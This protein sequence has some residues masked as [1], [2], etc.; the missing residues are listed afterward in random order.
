[1]GKVC[2]V[3]RDDR[4]E[5]ETYLCRS[6]KRPNPKKKNNKDEDKKCVIEKNKINDQYERARRC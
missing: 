3:S 6:R 4:K 1:M 5:I 2:K